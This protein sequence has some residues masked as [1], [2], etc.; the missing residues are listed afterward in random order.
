MNL[1]WSAQVGEILF[2]SICEYLQLVSKLVGFII[3]KVILC[4]FSVLE[5]KKGGL[6]SK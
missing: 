2:E 4:Q 3:K 5:K 1:L 6:R